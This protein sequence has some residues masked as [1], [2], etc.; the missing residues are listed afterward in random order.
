MQNGA[1]YKMRIWT[2]SEYLPSTKLDN[3][4]RLKLLS[5]FVPHWHVNGSR[6][7]RD[8]T[9]SYAMAI[10]RLGSFSCREKTRGSGNGRTEDSQRDGGGTY[11][12]L[13]WWKGSSDSWLLDGCLWYQWSVCRP[14]WCLF[15]Q[16]MHAPAIFMASC[17]AKS[18]LFLHSRVK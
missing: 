2:T 4:S 5:E 6:L 13:K 7:V 1:N 18:S 3:I 12:C 16:I 8:P 11:R 17:R 9:R 10:F 15:D 14:P